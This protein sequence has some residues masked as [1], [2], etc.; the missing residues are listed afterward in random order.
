[1]RKAQAALEFLTTYAWA[2]LSIMIAVGALYY[3]GVFNF[4][5]F[6]P[7]ECNFPS[8]FECLEFS[9]AYEDP[10]TNEVRFRLVN[11]IGEPLNVISFGI[12]NN[13]ESVLTCPTV[14]PASVP[15][16]N[17][18]DE[19]NIVFS[20]CTNGGFIRGDRMDAKITMTYCA[21]ATAGCPADTSVYHII[22]G[23]I[24]STVT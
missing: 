13:V 4:G 16:W 20:G 2:I 18:G 21:I 1:M 7:Q 10:I 17:P 14:T 15:T 23:K 11:N 5:K 24:T 6:L 3:F 8:Q 19:L 12:T 22:N 9:Y